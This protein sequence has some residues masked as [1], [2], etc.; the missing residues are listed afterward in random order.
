VREF[1]DRDQLETRHFRKW[2]DFAKKHRLGLDFNPSYFSH[3]KAQPFTLSSPE[4]EIRRFWIAHT[5][6]CIR[7][8]E[9]FATELGKPV[10]MNIWIPDGMKDIPADRLGPRAFSRFVGRGAV[11]AL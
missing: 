9:Y 6:A 2:L 7:I 10:L 8:S 11:D 5:K 3:A 4:P 1:A